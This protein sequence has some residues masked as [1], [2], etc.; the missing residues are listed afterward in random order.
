MNTTDDQLKSG[1]P[2]VSPSMPTTAWLTNPRVYAVH[3]SD[4]H[5][6]HAC[7][8]HAPASGE[9]SDLRQSLDG[10]WRVRVEAAP[11][12]CFP[13]GTSDG[14]DWISDVSPLFVAPGFD[15][16]SF[17]RIQVPSHLEMA[18]LL[19]PRY[20]NVQYPWDGHE[21]LEA[22]AVPADNHVAL[23]RRAFRPEGEVARA[24]ADGRRV[25]LTFHG[26]ATAVYVWLNGVFVGYG[27][28]SFTPSEFDVTAALRPGSNVLAVACYEFSSASWLEDQDFWRL[29]GLFR[30]VELTARPAAHV[31]DLKTLADWDP[32]A[33]QG[34]LT[35]DATIEGAA[36]ATVAD[37]TLTD[38]DG[39]T[40]VWQTA[41][42][43]VAGTSIADRSI[44]DTPTTNK[45]TTNTSTGTAS[46]GAGTVHA[47]AT[48]E[49]VDPWSA[50]TP[51][52]YTLTVTLYDTDG[53][54]LEAAQTSLGFRRIGIEDGVLKINGR[55]LILRGV[56]RHE[57]DCRRGRAVTEEDML[58]DVRFMKRHN[59][60][61]VRTSHYP[62]QSCW[63]DLC[64]EYGI[65]LIDETNLETHG[66]WNSPGDIPVGTSIPG[67]DP[68]WAPACLDRLDSMI[69]RDRNHPSVIIWSLGN[70]SY[71]GE[72]LKTMSEHAHAIDP[73]RPVHYEGVTWRREYEA[74]SDFESRMYAKPHEIR[75]WLE[76]QNGKGGKPRKPFMSCEY[77]HAMGNSCGGLDEFTDLESHECYAGGFIWDYIDQALV[78][79]LP[80]GT[81]RLSIG[82]D[83][84]DRP[85]DYEFAG[86]GIVF[87]DRTPSPKAQ[88][89]KQLY[90]PIRLTPD[91]HGVTIEN[92]NQFTGTDDYLFTARLLLDGREIWHC[93]YQFDVPAGQTTRHD[94]D[95]PDVHPD[96]TTREAVYQVEL[97]LAHAT[98]WAPAGYELAF[99]QLTG[100]INPEDDTAETG[101]DANR[102]TATVTLGRWNAGIRRDNEEILLS[103]TQGGIVS[104]KRDGR[105]MVIR[106]PDIVTFR[107]LTDNDRGNHSGFDRA[108]WYAAGRYAVVSETKIHENDGSLIAEYQYELADPN[109]TP[110]FIT[111]HIN[112]DMRMRLTVEYPGD[113]T[114]EA[115]L[116]AFGIEWELPGEYDRLRYYGPGP[117]ETYSDR[118]RGG[119]LGI[120]NTTAKTSMAPYLMV[121]ETGSHEDVRWLEVTDIQGHGLR[122]TQRADRRFTASLL[123]WNTYMIEAAR[124]N[125]DLPASRHS[126]LRLLAAQM[127]VGGDDSWGAP[128][129][130]AYQLPARRPFTLDI[131]LQLI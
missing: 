53:K 125:E 43:L 10:E 126:Y 67:D 127:G 104:W 44:T 70:E 81:E 5:S 62:N 83:W 37:V 15:D 101:H 2:I 73:T 7:W 19:P 115:S 92:R 61:A 106:R 11:A 58:W 107:P 77:M 98:S 59:I 56:N 51:N 66:S 33:K 100:T 71:A 23:Y 117:E 55:R 14:P 128:V 48:L 129:H 85:T 112:S 82:G 86:N 45:S 124:R 1:D 6:D 54:V 42:P 90:S 21:D 99:G 68:D 76:H 75:D 3:R 20:V 28:D 80:D 72:V 123:P 9:S 41:T 105:E 36:H 93:D 60:N 25:T 131:N 13:D 97:R 78:Q 122:V 63:Y 30:S 87:A 89:V 88:E 69:K 91:G 31:A 130:T 84:G 39:H 34:L 113:A 103:R 12:G 27:E 29:H 57:F 111:Y 95:Y 8:S 79:R 50:E 96:G 35:V 65:Y 26:A 46:T 4:A 119:K 17:S 109:H 116:P 49:G 118:K 16:S 108:A 47:E 32:D 102:A 18:G 94:I 74:I 52:L 114:S 64:D 22:P 110:V 24:V 120:W 121:Q 40:V 38:M